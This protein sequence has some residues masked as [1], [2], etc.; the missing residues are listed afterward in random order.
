MITGTG[1]AAFVTSD[2][3]ADTLQAERSDEGFLIRWTDGTDRRAAEERLAS[4]F[5]EVEH[6]GRQGQV[7]NLEQV[8]GY[9]TALGV[10]FALLGIGSLA[11]LCATAVRRR[12]RDLA[13]VKALGFTRSQVRAVLTWQ[14]TTVTFVGLLVGV[15][16]GLFVGRLSW[17]SVTQAVRIINEPVV[18]A[19]VLLG[20]AAGALLTVNALA[21]APGWIAARRP[22]AHELHTE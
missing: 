4:R 6:P 11:H 17:A 2:A 14:A 10:F 8:R 5:A 21:L 16:A 7:G 13:I 22:P 19:P 9:P 18:A 1:P 3:L 12:R 20:I 15:P